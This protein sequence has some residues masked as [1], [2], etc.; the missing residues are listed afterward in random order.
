GLLEAVE[1][2]VIRRLTKQ[3]HGYEFVH[4]LIQ[5]ALYDALPRAERARLHA[6]VADA[7]RARQASI[8]PR[9][10]EELAYHYLR[11]PDRAEDG[12]K[13]A[14]IAAERAF[15]KAAFDVAAGLYASALEA[16]TRI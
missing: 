3:F 16:A 4:S 13:H 1:N 14:L 6:A 12:I 15:S 7:L 9:S 5:E 11:A 8:L 10:S 2:G